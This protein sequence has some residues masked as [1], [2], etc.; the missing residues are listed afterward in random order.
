VDSDQA[1]DP[2]AS[3]HDLMSAA[4]IAQMYPEFA[5]LIT[6]DGTEY[7]DYTHELMRVQIRPAGE[8]L[9]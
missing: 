1:D 6:G 4:E 3:T 8:S 7:L 2:E 9:G 5:T